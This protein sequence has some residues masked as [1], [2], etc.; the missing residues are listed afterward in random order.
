[1]SQ[2]VIKMS[3]K[4]RYSH[5]MSE[6]ERSIF[7]AFDIFYLDDSA[8][9]DQGLRATVDRFAKTPVGD[10]NRST[11]QEFRHMIDE[12]SFQ[13]KQMDDTQWHAYLSA[14]W[15]FY[16]KSPYGLAAAKD[17]ILATFVHATGNYLQSCDEVDR[18]FSN[19]KV[20]GILP[21]CVEIINNL[22]IEW[23]RPRMTPYVEKD[24]IQLFRLTGLLEELIFD[25]ISDQLDADIINK[26][27]LS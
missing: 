15:V 13:I 1:M 3:I 18:E 21:L 22:D 8:L 16:D 17:D 2:N 6:A 5:R 24:L 14:F 19:E 4:G 27:F 11:D 7:D 23:A 25:E 20:V 26:V 9:F 10:T 12:M